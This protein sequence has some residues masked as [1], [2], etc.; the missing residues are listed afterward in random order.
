LGLARF[1]LAASALALLA[2]CQIP[3]ANKPQPVVSV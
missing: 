3:P 2:G 1:I